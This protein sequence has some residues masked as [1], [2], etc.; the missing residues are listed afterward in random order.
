M[1]LCVDGAEIDSLVC[2]LVEH[3]GDGL[4]TL[5][6]ETLL[7][8]LGDELAVVER[9]FARAE[10]LLADVDEFGLVCGPGS[11]GALRSALS[12]VN[13]YALAAGKRVVSVTRNGETWRVA[14]HEKSYVL[15]IYDRPAHTTP[16]SKDA[17]GRRV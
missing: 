2:A 16:S 6:Q 7:R 12:L 14:G 10:M 5:R 13:A 3:E 4:R 17:L 11:A 1:M 15:P 9:F 8:R